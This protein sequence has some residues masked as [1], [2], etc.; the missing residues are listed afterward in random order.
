MRA[1][2][3]LAVMA[4]GTCILQV[5]AT[6]QAAPPPVSAEP[7]G[8][9]PLFA[10]DFSGPD[11]PAGCRAY[12][13]PQRG[14]TASY[15]RPDDVAVRDGMLRLSM[16][17]REFDG[18]PYTTG[19]LG[20]DQLAQIYGRYEFRARVPAGAGI[21]S[22]VTLWPD[23]AGHDKHASLVE[24]LARPGDEK[25][26][27]TNQYGT[28]ATHQVVPGHYSDDFHTYVIEWAPS[29]FR[30]IVDG[31]T[32]LSDTHV[33]NRSKWI[34]FA[35][36]SGDRLTGVPDAATRLPAEFQVD[37][38]RV[39]SYDPRSTPVTAAQPAAP[40]GGDA[41]FTA[42]S[43]V[44]VVVGVA[45]L[46]GAAAVVVIVMIAWYGKLRARRRLRPAHRA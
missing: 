9:K 12:D 2:T 35:V 25:A 20:C 37:F 19:G 14:S 3:A 24:I 36:T 15:F 41:R 11:L 46:I 6:A 23:Q 32:R 40:G 22:F 45:G 29:A 17:R 26:Y 5:P 43:A 34:G 10:A 38:L 1:W 4:I 18:R 44:R 30:V 13:G 27:L 16:R 7:A 21:D 42:G 8:W 39:Y 31:A 33:S 28:S